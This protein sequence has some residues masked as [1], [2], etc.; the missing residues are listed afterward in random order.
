M[1]ITVA[2]TTDPSIA[3]WAKLTRSKSRKRLKKESIGMLDLRARSDDIACISW[4]PKKRRKR[5][6][7]FA[8]RAKAM[9]EISPVGRVKIEVRGLVRAWTSMADPKRRI[10]H[11]RIVRP[12]CRPAMALA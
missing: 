6:A 3:F 2:T 1:L 4:N 12:V 8:T 5:N 11:N 10:A 7:V 9:L